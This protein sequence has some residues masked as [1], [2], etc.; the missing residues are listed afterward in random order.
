MKNF[1]RI[2]HASKSEPK[3]LNAQQVL[4]KCFVIH[5]HVY[6]SGTQFT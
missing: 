4:M 5:L 3:K 6:A 2:K 1:G